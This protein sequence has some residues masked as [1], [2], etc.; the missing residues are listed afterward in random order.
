M[1]AIVFESAQW[2]RSDTPIKAEIGGSV[3]LAPSSAAMPVTT[4]RNSAALTSSY[5]DPPRHTR[6]TRWWMGS[7]IRVSA[8][9]TA[10]AALA[11]MSSS[12][13]S[14]R[15][16]ELAG[17]LLLDFELEQAELSAEQEALGHYAH[18]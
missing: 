3:L 17:L 7:S 8:G 13:A 2:C 11:L 4:A 1:R 16:V 14:A 18:M 9:A 15:K 12:S 10:Q 6:A 5:H